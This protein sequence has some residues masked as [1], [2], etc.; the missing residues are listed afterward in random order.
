MA[1]WPPISVT[2]HSTLPESTIAR[3]LPKSAGLVSTTR[4][5][6]FFSYPAK[7]ALRIAV[8]IEPPEWLTTIWA[9]LAGSAWAEAGPAALSAAAPPRR[10]TTSRRRR[11]LMSMA[12]PLSISPR[13]TLEVT[14]GASNRGRTGPAM[15]V[16]RHAR[17]LDGLSCPE[18]RCRCRQGRG[19]RGR[20][21]AVFRRR[22]GRRRHGLPQDLRNHAHAD[23]VDG[24]E[25]QGARPA[26]GLLRPARPDRA[27]RDRGGLRRELCPG[28]DLRQRRAGQPALADLPRASRRPAMARHT[29][30]APQQPVKLVTALLAAGPPDRP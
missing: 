8:P 22:H 24:G 17:A 23:G 20:H 21:R 25:S 29:S 28:Q 16:S 7:K 9:G 26:C 19:D 12:D 18:A 30:G 13:Q 5:P 4:M 6:Y 27:D 1:S 3:S 11:A 2:S 15:L 10:N 14:S